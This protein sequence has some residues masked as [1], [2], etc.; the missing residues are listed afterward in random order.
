MSN[1]TGLYTQIPEP[2]EKDEKCVFEFLCDKQWEDLEQTEQK[3]KRYCGDCARHVYLC[4]T[5]KQLERC[6]ARRD[7]VCY[8]PDQEDYRL[9]GSVET[10]TRD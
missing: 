9:I 5:E 7:C 6:Q 8:Q 3:S 1:K 10:L 4:N 2:K